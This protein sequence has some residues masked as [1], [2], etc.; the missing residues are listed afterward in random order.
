[1]KPIIMIDNYD[2]FTFNIVQYLLEIGAEVEVFENDKITIKELTA[3]D[4]EHLILSPGAATLT[5]Q[6]F[7]YQHLRI[8]TKAKK[9]SEFV[10]G[11]SALHNFSA[12]KL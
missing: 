3:M 4:F 1:M 8:F 11:I 7:A 10:S 2:S 12:A 5:P 6:G 9:S